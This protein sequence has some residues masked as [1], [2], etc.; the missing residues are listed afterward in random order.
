MKLHPTCA[1]NYI[2]MA[3]LLSSNYAIL[4]F[5]VLFTMVIYSKPILQCLAFGAGLWKSYRFNVLQTGKA[6]LL[7]EQGLNIILV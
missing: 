5:I 7:W 6:I 4:T 1:L 2:T 3:L